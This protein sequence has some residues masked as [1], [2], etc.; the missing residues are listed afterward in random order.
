MYFSII[1]ISNSVG[2]VTQ[3]KNKY[4]DNCFIIIC[5]TSNNEYQSSSW[6]FREI[7]PEKSKKSSHLISSSFIISVHI[8]CSCSKKKP[9][10]VCI[11][12]MNW[13]LLAILWEKNFIIAY[14]IIS[15]LLL[16]R[17]V[18]NKLKQ[19]LFI[20]VHEIFRSSPD[21]RIF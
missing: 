7:K 18:N 3:F 8:N 13:L 9:C 15:N 20:S 11:I 17:C 4:Y 6:L 1:S 19:S 10:N 2:R 5:S 16:M 14:R 12:Y 21:L